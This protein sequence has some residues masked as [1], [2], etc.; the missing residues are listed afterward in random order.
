[1]KI[2][3]ACPLAM[4]HTDRWPQLIAELGNIVLLEQVNF[5]SLDDIL[6]REPSY[7]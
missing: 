2:S 7:W 6:I 4:K 5:L 3:C 1:M